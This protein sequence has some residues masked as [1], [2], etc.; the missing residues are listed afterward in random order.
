MV[1]QKLILKKY[2]SYLII[3]VRGD[4]KCWSIRNFY[5]KEPSL[6]YLCTSNQI[7]LVWVLKKKKKKKETGFNNN[8]LYDPSLNYLCISKISQ[9]K[10]WLV[11]SPLS[12][13]KLLGT[14]EDLT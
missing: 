8:C 3:S 4:E 6:N 13:G 1:Q 9:K 12:G 11:Y 2:F 5:I 7:K 10:N 14:S